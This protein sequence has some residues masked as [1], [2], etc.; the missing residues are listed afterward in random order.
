MKANT[1]LVILF[2]TASLILVKSETRLKRVISQLLALGAVLL[3][4][5]H[6]RGI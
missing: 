2:S 5:L 6:L 3:Q 1:A 4:V